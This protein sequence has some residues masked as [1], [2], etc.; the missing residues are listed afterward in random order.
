MKDFDLLTE[1][2][3]YVP[4]DEKERGYVNSVIDFLEHGKDQFVRTNLEK[5]IVADA[6][7]LSSSLDKILLTHH[8]ALGYWLPFGGHSDGDSN[9]L[10][11]ALREAFEES[12]ISNIDTGEGKIFDVDI[13]TIP[14]NKKKN[15]PEHKHIDIRFIFT[16]PEKNFVV[17]DESD[18]LA[19]FD[20]HEFEDMILNSDY[21]SGTNRVIAKL[22]E[23]INS[24]AKS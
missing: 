23:F 6:Y 10:H 4:Y 19:W 13:H 11:V 17:S 12:G 1:L 24:K 3:K 2:K 5:H 22:E 14:E 15:E 20:I 18:T 16:T 8:K 7:L 9:S 21:F